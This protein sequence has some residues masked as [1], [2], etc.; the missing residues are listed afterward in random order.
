MASV[1]N[2]AAISWSTDQSKVHLL[3]TGTLMTDLYASYQTLKQQQP[4]LRMLEAAKTLGVSEAQLLAASV[5]DNTVRL[6]D[7]FAGMLK[8]MKNLGKV[9]ALVRNE[10]VVSEITGLYEKIYVQEEQGKLRGIAINPGGIDLRFFFTNWHS[11]FA[12]KVGSLHSIQFFDQYGCAIQK[13]YLKQDDDHDK[14]ATFVDKFKHQQQSPELKVEVKQAT[15]EDK[16]SDTEVNIGALEQAWLGM[17]DLHQFPSVLAEHQVGR[18]QAL[19]LVS[20]KLAKPV[21][22][23]ALV[24]LLEAAQSEQEEIMAFVGNSGIVQIFSGRVNTLKQMGS[25]YNVLDLEF[26]LH[27]NVEGLTEAFV[28]H[29]PTDEG[30]VMVSSVEFLNAAGETILTFFGRRVEGK[31]QSQGWQALVAKI[32]QA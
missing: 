8:A 14:Y 16:L 18:R 3:L 30:D 23:D 19:R 24:S 10:H 9:M 31:K 7:D 15:P 25:W 27:V 4:K 5:G 28:V 2:F 13:I 11:S 20:D 32:E 17:T 12:T 29:K 6:N 1:V 26:N 21:A 22:V